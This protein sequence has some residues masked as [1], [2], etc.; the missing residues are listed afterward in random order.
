MTGSKQTP[1]A[2]ARPS[3]DESAVRGLLENWAEAV[4]GHDLAGVLAH[5]AQELVYFDV[6]PP[7]QVRGIDA[8]AKSW[9]PFFGY[10][11]QRGQFELTELGITA[12]ED[13][14][15]AHAILLVRGETETSAARVR[16]T[17]GLRKL[18]GAWCVVHEHH[19][20]PYE[21]PSD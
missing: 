15:F 16:L 17:V 11:G 10:I 4:R 3:R 19:S 9:P 13:V 2:S 20:A 6:P 5:H 12:S 8:Y 18:Q 7:E 1:D 21:L 14:A